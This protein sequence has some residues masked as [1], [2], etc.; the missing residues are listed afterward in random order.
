MPGSG[1]EMVEIFASPGS[2]MNVETADARA[3]EYVCASCKASVTLKPKDPIRCGNCGKN[4]L[5]KSRDK[6]TPVQMRAV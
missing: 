1:V 5:Y 4:I 3:S 6:N 2:P